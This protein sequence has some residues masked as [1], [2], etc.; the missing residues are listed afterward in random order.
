MNPVLKIRSVVLALVGVCALV[1]TSRAYDL[2][3]LG[4]QQWKYMIAT[5]EASAPIQ[6]WRAVGFNDASW[7]IGQTPI[8]YTTGGTLT[9]YEASIVPPMLR[10]SASAPTYTSVYFRK[11]FQITNLAGLSSLVLSVYADDGAVAWINGREA[12]RV[13]VPVTADL[14]FSATASVA[15]EE[16][17]FTVSITDFSHLVVGDNVLAIHG[18]NGNTTSSDLH[19]QARLETVED[20]AP[21]AEP[22]PPP[23]AIVTTLTFIN[24]LFTEGVTGVDAADLLI[25]D[26]AASSMQ[27]N[28][29]NDYTFY[30]PQPPTGGVSVAWA[31]THGIADTDGAPTAFGGGSWTYTLDP[32]AI[33]GLFVISEFM[34]ENDSGVE[35]EDGDRS[36]WIEIFNPGAVESSL[37]GW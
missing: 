16:E 9:G 15:D 28:N 30:F 32:N 13:N 20:T 25:N 22:Q 35:D 36:D 33:T 3:P 27:V 7:S 11:T 18:F 6:A 17:E 10:T 24:V 34:A 21:I 14:P 31:S 5:Q 2:I 23:N 1:N 4:A 37:A 8:G 29:P 26:V 19:M 12:G